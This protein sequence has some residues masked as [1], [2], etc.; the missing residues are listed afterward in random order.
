MTQDR[1]I[2]FVADMYGDGTI[3][4]GWGLDAPRGTPPAAISRISAEFVKAFE[5]PKFGE[6]LDKQFADDAVGVCGIP[7][8]G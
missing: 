7:E 2:G 6:F 5:D 4:A 3:S 8:S 1:Y